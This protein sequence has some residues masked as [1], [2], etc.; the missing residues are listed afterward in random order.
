M[1]VHDSCMWWVPDKAIQFYAWTFPVNGKVKSLN[2]YVDLEEIWIE[3]H[4]I[5][6]RESSMLISLFFLLWLTCA[7]ENTTWTPERI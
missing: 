3:T 7:K 5:H 6:Q 2:I 4:D 1:S